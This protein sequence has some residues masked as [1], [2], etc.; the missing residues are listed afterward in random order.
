MNKSKE[1]AYVKSLFESYPSINEFHFTKDGNAFEQKHNA[2]SHASLLDTKNPEVLTI[3]R[4]DLAKWD[5]DGGIERAPTDL[6]PEGLA[7]ST[8][9]ESGASSEPSPTDPKAEDPAAA[10]S[11]EAGAL[12][13]DPAASAPSVKGTRTTTKPGKN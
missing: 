4:E 12:T 13:S 11:A 7:A 10:S 8:S 9:A 3:T 1:M 5:S 6:I 2:E